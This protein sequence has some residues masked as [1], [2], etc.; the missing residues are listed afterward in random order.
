MSN[1]YAKYFGW[2]TERNCT[3][4]LHNNQPVG[5]TPIDQ[6]LEIARKETESE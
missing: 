1:E 5:S 3:V 4:Y 2:D 6:A